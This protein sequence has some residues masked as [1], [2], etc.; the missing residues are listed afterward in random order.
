MTYTRKPKELSG[1]IAKIDRTAWRRGKAT[2]LA[3]LDD[4]RG[5]LSKRGWFELTADP[6][7]CQI[8][9]VEPNALQMPGQC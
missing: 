3:Y 8:L 2:T 7:P 6:G 1:A 9:P 4:Q 5:S